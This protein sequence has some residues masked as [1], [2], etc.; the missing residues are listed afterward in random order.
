MCGIVFATVIEGDL[1]TCTEKC[2]NRG[3]D[4]THSLVTNN[5]YFGFNRL[6]IHDL[7]DAGSQPFTK[8]DCVLI[9]NGEIYN[10]RLLN[11]PYERQSQSDCEVILDIYADMV[12]NRGLGISAMLDVLDGEFAFVIHDIQLNRTIIARDPNGVRPLF[13]CVEDDVVYAASLLTCID[14][15]S[16]Q[17]TQF[18]P[19]HYSVVYHDPL[20]VRTYSYYNTQSLPHVRI[21]ERDQAIVA[22]RWALENAVIKRLDSERE[23]C[24]LL[25]GGLDSSLVAAI[26]SRYVRKQGKVLKT[27]SI[28]LARSPDTEYAEIASKFI[29]SDHTTVTLS[30]EQFLDAIAETISVI[31]SYDVTTVRASVGNYL[32]CKHISRETSCK[33]VLNGDYSDEVAG[34]Y[35]YFKN[36]PDNHSFDRE[37]HRLLRDVCFFDSLRSDRSISANGLEG[38]VPFADKNYVSTY[39]CI[40]AHLRNMPIEKQLLR[41]AFHGH[42]Y[43]PDEVLWRKKEAFSDGVSQQTTSWKDIIQRYVEDKV[44]IED[45][46]NAAQRFPHN[47]PDTKEAYL[48]RTLFASKFA[49][50][51]AIPYKWMPKWVDPSIKDPSARSLHMYDAE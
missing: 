20:N 37:C 8:H 22:I 18:P 41:E 48:Y 7:T 29:G 39:L 43:L 2:K 46:D 4:E 40:D 50:D 31:E 30:E 49:N 27:F 25:S 42:A 5:L 11:T 32:L 1:D 21:R 44:S 47:T 10:H 45:M 23:V 14:G 17:V 3:P 15:M 12:K 38:R 13:W 6:A 16:N 34:G 26:A 28:G 33:V 9:C 24:A 51:K 36:A 19:G 35:L